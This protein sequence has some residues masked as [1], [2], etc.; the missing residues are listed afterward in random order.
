MH[1]LALDTLGEL[2][3]H[4]RVHLDGVARLA[5]LED[6]DREIACSGADLE[7]DIRGAKVGLVDDTARCE[8][9]DEH[10]SV[11]GRR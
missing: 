8:G 1:A 11:R 2:C 9:R 7:N 10:V 3:S 6:A 5:L 4:A